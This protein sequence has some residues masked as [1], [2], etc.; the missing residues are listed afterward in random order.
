MTDRERLGRLVRETWVAWALE[1]PDAKPSWLVPWEELD[2]GQRE[3]DIR[4]GEA[5]VASVT[6]GRPHQENY[7]H[8]SENEGGTAVQVQP[9]CAPA[10]GK[11][12]D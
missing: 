1:Q 2:D 9:Q 11:H 12:D 8:R 5:V 6:A 4:I 3:V 10:S 7:A